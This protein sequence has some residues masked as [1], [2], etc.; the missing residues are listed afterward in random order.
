MTEYSEGEEIG[1]KPRAS[2]YDGPWEVGSEKSMLGLVQ[3]MAMGM[4]M[5]SGVA[6]EL[7]ATLAVRAEPEDTGRAAAAAAAV[8]GRLSSSKMRPRYPL[9]PS[10]C[11]FCQSSPSVVIRGVPRNCEGAGDACR[12][13]SARLPW[14][15]AEICWKSEMA[16]WR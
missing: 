10:R 13:W 8:A 7:G 9:M 16:V 2:G 11:H 14:F 3:S 5:A 4:G 15:C 6:A 12:I 1:D